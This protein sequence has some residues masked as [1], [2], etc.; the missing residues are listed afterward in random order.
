MNWQAQYGVEVWELTYRT[1]DPHG[2]P[3]S[4]TGI[5]V[6]PIDPGEPVPLVSYHHGTVV[7]KNGAPSGQ[8]LEG[9]AVGLA[10]ASTG[11]AA[12]MP[13]FLG[14]G[15]GEGLHPYQHARSEATACV[16]MLRACRAL[17]AQEH[18]PLS[19]QLFL[20]GYSQGGHVTLAVQR[21]L[22][23]FHADEFTVTAS[24]PMAGAYDMS[25]V[26][27]NDFLSGREVPN[28][29]Y[30][31]YLLAAYQDV[32]GLTNSLASY[33]RPPYDTTLPPMFDG[34]HSGSEINS[35]MPAD[36]SQVLKPEVLAALRADPLHPLRQALRDNDLLDWT[37][38][39]PVRLFH[40]SGDQDVL[41][42]NSVVALESFQARGADVQLINPL[43][44]ADHGGCVLPSM[45]AAKAW[46][47]LL[48]H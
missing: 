11:Y 3:T 22:E 15:G 2:M 40:C 23:T 45:L 38:R 47:D 16:D 8:D 1:V 5:A 39:A 48:R 28:P 26:M 35:A 37:P 17:A 13:D 42:A 29:Y 33:L 36:P 43:P 46:F 18:L 27:F 30:Y 24:A 12:A 34:R 31:G 25:G 4:A 14:L 19:D 10:Y 20:M 41:Y 21:E 9:W 32:Y 6:L 44:G 7:E